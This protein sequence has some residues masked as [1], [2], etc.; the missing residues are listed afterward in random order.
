MKL[1]NPH[2]VEIHMVFKVGHC[3][4]S[5]SLKILHNNIV[6]SD[7]ERIEQNYLTVDTKITLPCTLSF[8]TGNKNLETD[9]RLDENGQIVEDKFI[10]VTDI[11]LG[12]YPVNLEKSF[13]GQLY[14]WLPGTVNLHFD[15]SNFLL[16]HLKNNI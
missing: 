14:W 1:N 7:F 6:I 9:T 2:A 11:R 5:M 15:E 12:R 8:V 3:N 16:W 10:Q 13:D 4:G